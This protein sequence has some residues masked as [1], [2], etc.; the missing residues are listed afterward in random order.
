MKLRIYMF[1]KDDFRVWGLTSIGR[2]IPIY[3]KITLKLRNI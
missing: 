2:N 1:H 3:E